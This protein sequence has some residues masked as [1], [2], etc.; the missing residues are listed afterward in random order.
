M[1]KI[2]KRY[3]DKGLYSAEDVAKFVK[4]GKLTATEFE[5]ITGEA[6]TE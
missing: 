5:E 6:Y 2:V 1:K 4:A 3:Y